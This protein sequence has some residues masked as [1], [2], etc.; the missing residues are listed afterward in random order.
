VAGAE[1]DAYLEYVGGLVSGLRRVAY[2]LSHDWHRADD[3]VQASLERLYVHWGK[4]QQAADPAAYARTVLIRLF[5]SEQRTGWAR[6]VVLLDG[7]LEAAT[8]AGPDLE[9]RLEVEAALRELPPRQR[10]VLV[11]R[12]YCDLSVEQTAT[13]LRCAPGTV[14]SQA[15]RGLDKLR[16]ALA[17]NDSANVTRS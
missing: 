3:L 10:A 5:L 6:R 15:A 17:G 2:L 4:A 9:S 11:L 14:K 7:G 1:D 8:A 12:F 16:T 13:V